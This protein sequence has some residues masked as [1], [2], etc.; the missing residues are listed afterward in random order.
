MLSFQNT[1]GQ[2][3]TKTQ[4]IRHIGYLSPPHDVI[5]WLIFSLK[6]AINEYVD[7]E[8]QLKFVCIYF[9]RKLRSVEVNFTAI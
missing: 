6:E 5:T 3:K 2:R 9:L 7:G 4:L 1:E 8:I